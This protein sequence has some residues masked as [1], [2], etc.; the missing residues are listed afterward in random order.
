MHLSRAHEAFTNIDHLL[1]GKDNLNK[2]PEL[3]KKMQAV[4]SD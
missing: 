1:A 4:F 3:K 2:S